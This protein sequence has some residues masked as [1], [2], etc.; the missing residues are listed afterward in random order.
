MIG[1]GSL[2]TNISGYLS[3]E[4]WLEKIIYFCGEQ[5]YWSYYHFIYFIHILCIVGLCTILQRLTFDTFLLI[6][7]QIDLLDNVRQLLAIVTKLLLIINLFLKII[8]YSD[9][10]ANLC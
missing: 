5:V 2:V 7:V 9:S 4:V 8:N 10:A 3:A 1:K 6:R